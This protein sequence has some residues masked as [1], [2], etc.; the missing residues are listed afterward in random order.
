MKNMPCDLNDYNKQSKECNLCKSIYK[1]DYNKCK[2]I[3]ECPH[4][5][6]REKWHDYWREWK[7]FKYCNLKKKKCSPDL[8]CLKIIKECKNE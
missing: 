8:K 3:Y 2:T 7:R 6:Q 5:E 4:K 1:E